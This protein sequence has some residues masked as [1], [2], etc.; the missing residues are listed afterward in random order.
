[1]FIIGVLAVGTHNGMKVILG[2]V[3]GALGIDVI[4][5]IIWKKEIE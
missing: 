1:M 2:I 5:K 3:F 4:K